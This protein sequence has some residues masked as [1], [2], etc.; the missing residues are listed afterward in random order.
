MQDDDEEAEQY[1]LRTVGIDLV[2]VSSD[3]S[4][5]GSLK[6]R[7]SFQAMMDKYPRPIVA[8]VQAQ[9]KESVELSAMAKRKGSQQ[10]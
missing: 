3:I 7:S 4:L 2:G 10:W 8:L 1:G 6:V 5:F 9:T